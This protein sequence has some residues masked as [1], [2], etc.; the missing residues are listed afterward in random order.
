MYIT[1]PSLMP[2]IYHAINTD[3][4]FFLRRIFHLEKTTTTMGC[5]HKGEADVSKV[6]RGDS[7]RGKVEP[8]PS[9]NGFS[10]DHCHMGW[11]PLRVV[12][13]H[14]HRAVVGQAKGSDFGG[15]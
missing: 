11:V 5:V 14:D 13:P 7:N 6:K 9:K 12:S 2:G 1:T 8:I 3:L 4:Q 15:W 10:I